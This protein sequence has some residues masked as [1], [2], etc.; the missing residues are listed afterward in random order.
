MQGIGLVAARVSVHVEIQLGD[1]LTL[2]LQLPLL[3]ALALLSSFPNGAPIQLYDVQWHCCM[4][5]RRLHSFEPDPF[6]ECGLAE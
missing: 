3:L 1:I 4:E 5:R 2:V 6:G